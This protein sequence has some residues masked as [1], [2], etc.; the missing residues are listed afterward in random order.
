MN[1]ATGYA[2]LVA[3]CG[4]S[5]RAFARTA[6]F[7]ISDTMLTMTISLTCFGPCPD[8]SLSAMSLSTSRLSSVQVA[9]AGAAATVTARHQFHS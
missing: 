3:D 8:A 1:A 4:V 6:P 9:I 7:M 2:K 5:R